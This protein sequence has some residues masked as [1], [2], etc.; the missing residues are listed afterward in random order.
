M[1]TC[2]D[3]YQACAHRDG[4]GGSADAAAWLRRV[5]ANTELSD[6]PGSTGLAE[7]RAAVA[8]LPAATARPGEG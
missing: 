5:L 6:L 1:R 4:G 3:A 7:L 2:Y 8:A